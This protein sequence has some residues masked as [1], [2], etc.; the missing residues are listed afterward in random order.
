[1]KLYK[2]SE[3]LFID[4]QTK[5]KYTLS[6]IESMLEN[7]LISKETMLK[8][9]VSNV[10]KVVPVEMDEAPF[11]VRKTGIENILD[12]QAETYEKKFE[13]EEKLSDLIM[14]YGKLKYNRAEGTRLN[15]TLNFKT[16][17]KMVR[18]SYTLDL[19]NPEFKFRHNNEEYYMNASDLERFFADLEKIVL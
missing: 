13:Y 17:N 7:G 1:M 8:L 16:P 5:E 19:E 12:R 15:Y 11:E 18:V 2:V 10:G 6:I 4:R 3:H 14:G 9:M